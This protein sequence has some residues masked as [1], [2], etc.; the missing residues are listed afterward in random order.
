LQGGKQIQKKLEQHDLARKKQELERLLPNLNFSDR[1]VERYYE[2]GPQV[3]STLGRMNSGQK[4]E[5]NHEVPRTRPKLFS[6]DAGAARVYYRREQ[7]QSKLYIELIG[8][9]NTQDADYKFLRQRAAAPGRGAA[10]A[11]G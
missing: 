5:G 7:G 1:A 3:Q 9:K 8:D 4:L 10:G 6:A 2:L 11:G